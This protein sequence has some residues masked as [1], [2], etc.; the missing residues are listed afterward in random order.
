MNIQKHIDK[1][2]TK[3][4]DNLIICWD[5]ERRKKLFNMAYVAYVAQKTYFIIENMYIKSGL[6][7][8]YLIKYNKKDYKK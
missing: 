7:L 8:E 4:C 2:N 3:K 5:P 1:K 6:S